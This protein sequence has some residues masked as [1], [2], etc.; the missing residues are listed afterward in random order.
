[1]P[2]LFSTAL[3]VEKNRLESDHVW[4][5]LFRI[6]I[7]GAPGPFRLAAYDQDVVFHG[8]TFQRFSVD[9]DA[10][11]QPTHAALVHLRATVANI[12][13]QVQSLLETYW[14]PIAS[15]DWQVTIFEVDAQQPNETDLFSGEVFTV[16]QV[17]TVWVSATFDLI[18]EGLTLNTNVP[19]RRYTSSGGFE[20]IPSRT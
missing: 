5:M 12:D 9:L 13:Q 10:I 3:L 8:D 4:C 2:R 14:A 18:A 20:L 11:E 7:T 1:M 17:T 15:P 16:Q 6:D 19:K